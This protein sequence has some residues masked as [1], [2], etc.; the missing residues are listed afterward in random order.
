VI[1]LLGIDPGFA[2]VGLASVKLD[3]GTLSLEDFAVLRTS[4]SARKQRVLASD[5]NFRRARELT[6]M[7]V[8]ELEGRDPG[9]G[10]PGIQAVCAE[11]MSYPRSSSVAAKMAMCWGVL[12]ALCE[13]R[14]LAMVQVSPQEVKKCLCGVRDASKER[15]QAALDHRFPNARGLLTKLAIPKSLQEHPYDAL[16]AVV[17]CAHSEVVVAMARMKEGK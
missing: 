1:H 14:R 13:D 12:A 4:K 15:V 17:A 10:P 6:R 8:E 2:S 7:L 3:R 16:A 11:A 5:D 9:E